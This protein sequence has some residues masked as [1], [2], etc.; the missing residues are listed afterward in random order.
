[1]IPSVIELELAVDNLRSQSSKGESKDESIRQ[2]ENKAIGIALRIITE[3]LANVG[4]EANDSGIGS[5]VGTLTASQPSLS[6]DSANLT[7]SLKVGS[8]VFQMSFLSIKGKYWLAEKDLNHIL[9][10]WK[11][12]DVLLKLDVPSQ[13]L[14]KDKDLVFE[15]DE[16]LKVMKIPSFPPV[17]SIILLLLQA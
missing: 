12:N 8:D 7:T 11:D 9:P 17:P 10:R 15:L 4:V 16:V 5:Q 13:V 3:N 2:L 6:D 14:S 1:M